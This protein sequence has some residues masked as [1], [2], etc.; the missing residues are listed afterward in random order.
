MASWRGKF[1][2]VGRFVDTELMDENVDERP[3]ANLGVDTSMLS[4]A[5]A[6]LLFEA[7]KELAFSLD[8]Y[9]S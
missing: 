5:A 9:E 4:D 8:D 6:A 2:L 3:W 1:R 7:A